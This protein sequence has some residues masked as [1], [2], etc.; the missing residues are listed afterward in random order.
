MVDIIVLM[1]NDIKSL[2]NT[3][4]SIS[5]QNNKDYKV[6]IVNNTD[7]D[8]DNKF[9]MFNDLNI[10][11]VK[12]NNKDNLKNIGINNS[13]SKYI[14]FINSGDLFYNCF[15]I[16]NI[17]V[18]IDKYDIITGKIAISYDNKV[19]YY[20]DINRYT[21]GKIYKRDFIKKNKLKFNN[22]KYYSDMAFNK[23]YIMCKARSALCRKEVYFTSNPMENDNNKDYIVDYCKSFNKCI[24]TSAKMKLDNKDIS[25]LIYTNILYLYNKYNINNKLKNIIIKNGKKIYNYYLEYN[26]Y[27]SFN[28]KDRINS[29]YRLDIEYNCSLYEFLDMFNVND[30]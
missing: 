18:D 23:L 13:N 14:L 25:Y 3:L 28:D 24:E 2:I 22:C 29:D 6:I 19:D 7:I 5:F 15:S 26:K 16:S 11:I 27:L 17:L 9:D 12:S 30:K 10:S 21:Y 20:D 1:N 8:L 4:G